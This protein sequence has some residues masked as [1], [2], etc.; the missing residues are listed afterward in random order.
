MTAYKKKKTS[1]IKRN[2]ATQATQATKAK[3]SFGRNIIKDIND[4][5]KKYPLTS[6]T[7]KKYSIAWKLMQ[8][9]PDIPSKK[10]QD[11][12]KDF[13]LG[14]DSRVV[15]HVRKSVKELPRAKASKNVL[16]SQLEELNLV[17]GK[18]F[19][20]KY[21]PFSLIEDVLGK[22]NA[23]FRGFEDILDVNISTRL[24][25]ADTKVR[26]SSAMEGK[27]DFS[28]SIEYKENRF[29]ET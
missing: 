8:D 15:A 4:V 19:T 7:G 1:A 16:D 28:V 22:L 29:K 2:K 11:A 14:S 9:T 13:G 5:Y 20:Q 24:G 25:G 18:D 26:F 3:D 6:K 23:V 12:F 10:V 21:A 17:M 27:Y